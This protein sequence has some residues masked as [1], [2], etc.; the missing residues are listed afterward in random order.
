MQLPNRRSTESQPRDFVLRWLPLYELVN[1]ATN[2]SEADTILFST[3]AVLRKSG[4]N[5]PVVTDTADTDAYVVAA[6]LSHQLPGVLCNLHQEKTG[7][8]FL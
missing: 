2:Q 6:V 5:D 7:Y 4:C 3:Y 8:G 1:R